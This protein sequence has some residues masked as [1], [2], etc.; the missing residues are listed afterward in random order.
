[1]IDMFFERFINFFFFWG[2]W[3]LAP[4]MIDIV[5]AFI[6]L[7]TIMINRK[8][9]IDVDPVDNL[10]F[11]PIVSLIV[12]VHNSADTLRKCLKSIERQNYP[13]NLMQVICVNN[14]SNDK[15][16]Q[17][18][19]Q[20]QQESPLNVS[21][22]ELDRTGKSI[23]LNAGLYICEG[24]YIINVDS[25]CHL[26]KDAVQNMVKAFEKEPEMVAATGAIHI[27]KELGKG[28]NFID[29]VH[30]CE[31]IE[32]VVAFNIG[33]QYQTLTNTLFTLSG[34]FSAFRRDIILNSFL[35]SETTVSEDTEL[36]FHLREKTKENKGQLGCVSKSIAYVEPIT[37]ISKLY[38]QRVRWQ[39]GQIE[40][41][42]MYSSSSK[43]PLQALKAIGGRI[44][45][46]D[47]TLA[48]SRLTWTFLIPILYFFGYP[49][50]LVMAAVL[51]M[52]ICYS[53]LDLLYLTV[54]YA[55]SSIEIRKGLKKI[56]WVVFFL[57]FFRYLTYWFRFAGIILTMTEPGTWRTENPFTQTKKAIKSNIYF[58]REKLL[59]KK[60]ISR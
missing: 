27:D 31:A 24:T 19:S 8:K 46:S 15:S 26:D 41:A 38:S 7:F 30:Y 14:G 40:V 1:M 36:T 10:S 34:A 50:N 49:L 33:R 11:L 6:Y 56:W 4:L 47:H 59:Q 55:G 35:Y 21:W 22:S 54:A 39:R 23:A 53:M 28:Y 44:L 17:I 12:P 18:F 13:I 32:Y 51:G 37:N 3:M 48:L 58:I 25:D 2:V 45:I 42:S 20:F 16:F 29:I 57:P 9:V 60:D 52:L 43:N 5:T